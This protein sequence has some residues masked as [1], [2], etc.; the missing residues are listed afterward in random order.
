MRDHFLLVNV[1]KPEKKLIR[2]LGSYILVEKDCKFEVL[3]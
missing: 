3:A 1:S 2:A